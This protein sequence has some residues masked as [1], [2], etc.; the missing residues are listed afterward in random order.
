MQISN[1]WRRSKIILGIA[2]IVIVTTFWIVFLNERVFSGELLGKT[3]STVNDHHSS[4][5]KTRCKAPNLVERHLL[6]SMISEICDG[7]IAATIVIAQLTTEV[8]KFDPS[9]YIKDLVEQMK[10]YGIKGKRI[11]HYR[12]VCGR[13]TGEMIQT[14]LNWKLYNLPSK[15]LL[16]AIDIEGRSEGSD[17]DKI[18]NKLKQQTGI[19]CSYNSQ[20]HRNKPLQTLITEICDGNLGAEKVLAKLTTESGND[21]SIDQ[22][23][24]VSQLNKYGI[25]GKLIWMFYKDVCGE[26]IGKMIALLRASKLG[27]ITKPVLFHAI[28]N[29]GEWINFDENVKNIKGQTGSDK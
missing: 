15:L 23:G 24:L 4:K 14:L 21:L 29:Y 13:D 12:D 5:H 6:S 3:G 27:I 7:N 11:L 18:M 16:S 26:S 20:V 2:R 1:Y 9:V 17:T 10:E 19:E 25:K 8:N 28:S 22:K